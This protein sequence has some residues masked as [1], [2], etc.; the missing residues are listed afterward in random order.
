MS[1][2]PSNRRGPVLPVS[3]WE[4]FR[5]SF[6][7]EPFSGTN[8]PSPPLPPSSGD[9]LEDLEFGFESFAIDEMLACSFLIR[10]P[11]CLGTLFRLDG[12]NPFGRALLLAHFSQPQR[13]KT[14]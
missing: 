4:A 10:M 7:M 1:E 12:S 8:E 5:E 14:F 13:R 3:F 6:G 9:G 2:K 11:L